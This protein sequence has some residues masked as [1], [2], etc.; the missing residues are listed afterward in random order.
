MHYTG[1]KSA[2]QISGSLF[3]GLPDFLQLK[4]IW[5]WMHYTDDMLLIHYQDHQKLQLSVKMPIPQ[6]HIT[7]F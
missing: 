3:L 5:E 7:P 4:S 6:F 2:L 1:L